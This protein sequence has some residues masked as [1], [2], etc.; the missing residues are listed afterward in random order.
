M[1]A[2]AR[3]LDRRVERQQIG[4][5]RDLLHDGDLLGDGL[6]RLDRAADRDA[7]GLGVGCADCRAIFSVW[8]AL[9]AFCLMFAAISSI[10]EEASSADEACSVAP[11]DSC[12]ALA[13]SS[14]LPD[15]T[16]C[17]A[18]VTSPTTARSFA[19]MFSSAMPSVSLSDCGLA[20]TVRS[21][22]AIASATSAVAFRLTVI[23]LSD[24]K[25]SPI[26]SL[27]EASI[28]LLRSP[29]ATASARLT[30][31]ERP[32]E[33][34]I[35]IQVAIAMPSAIAPRTMAIIIVRVVS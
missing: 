35:A 21:P 4:L 1:F 14:W 18:V 10:E 20:S 11:C 19:T 13:E 29:I 5:A 3:R 28:V 2:G 7:A 32:F 24:F 12:S 31:R 9:S 23:L 30:A 6:H 15:D 22:P 25:R 33:I 27:P 34:E 17:A 8:P 16:F 26:S